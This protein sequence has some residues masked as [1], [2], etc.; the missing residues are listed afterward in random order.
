MTA[1]ATRP[2]TAK[3]KRPASQPETVRPF[4]VR[5]FG[6]ILVLSVILVLLL[7]ILHI[8]VGTAG[9]SPF[10]VLKVLTGQ[11]VD[12][13]TYNVVYELR[14]PRALVAMG[15]GA[16]LA[17]SGAILQ[18][19]LRNPL[20]DPDLTG[21]ATGGVFFAVLYLS[22]DKLGWAFAPG[23]LELPVVALIGALI[24]GGLVY[25]VSWKGGSNPVRLI[26]TG[27]LFAT[28][29]RAGTSLIL[30]VNQNAA[31][32][33]FLWI[34]GSLNGR[35][36]TEWNMLWPWAI[37]TIPVGLLS[38]STANV[39]HLG[40]D[41]ARGLGMRIERGRLLLLAAAILL[42][43]GAVSAVG[44]LGFLGLIA[45]HI[46]RRIVG[47]D[48]RRIFP[49]SVTI[50]AGLL[51]LADIVSRGL[52]QPLELPVGAVMSFLGAPFLIYLLRKGAK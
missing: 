46:A 28:V 40:D 5:H 14:L 35:T 48:A 42:T 1:V 39:L 25:F 12:K 51:L 29:M 32:S 19:T 27:V 24:T 30:L 8:N 7:L 17:L 2:T 23:G 3:P 31:G 44:A 4:A 9:I 52:T 21:A 15:A 49:M 50:G 36:W 13:I 47:Q 18:S 34:V 16:M 43:A 26:L 22:R 10:D 45:P 37:V 6:L 20:A 41:T 11:P 33:I 38:A